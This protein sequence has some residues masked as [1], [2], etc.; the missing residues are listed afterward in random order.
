MVS[1]KGSNSC[2]ILKLK[3][4]LKKNWNSSSHIIQ[5][6]S[7]RNL[8]TRRKKYQENRISEIFMNLQRKSTPETG[9]E[10]AVLD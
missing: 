8:S 7:V 2:F 3:R 9:L 4:V 1:A 6:F 10:D 5:I